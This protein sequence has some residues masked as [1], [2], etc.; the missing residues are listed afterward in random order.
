MTI[1]LGY[2]EYLQNDETLNSSHHD[3]IHRCY[4]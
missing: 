2:L 1:L 4:D 3:K